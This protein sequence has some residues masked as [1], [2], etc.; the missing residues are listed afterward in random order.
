MSLATAWN[1]GPVPLFLPALAVWAVL[2]VVLSAPTARAL[3][4]SR[5]VAFLVLAS[6]GLTLTATLTPT[7]E[8]VA[9]EVLRGGTC[10]LRQMGLPSLSQLLRPND[11][12]L[13]VLL[14]VPL[15]FAL[16]LLP[17]ARRSIILIVLAFAVPLMIETL[18]LVLVGLGRGCESGDVINN[19]LGLAIGLGIAIGMRAV[20]A[21]WRSASGA[22]AG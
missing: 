15:G 9:G 20:Y 1:S 4:T 19:M 6:L 14:F 12:S 10:S 22:S 16:G 18:Q 8:A 13:N 2:S 21:W 7:S 17:L 5:L 11:V 3:D